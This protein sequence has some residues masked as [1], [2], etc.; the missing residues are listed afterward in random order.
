[1]IEKYFSQKYIEPIEYIA[2]DNDFEYLRNDGS[3]SMMNITV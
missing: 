1:M 2:S 3:K